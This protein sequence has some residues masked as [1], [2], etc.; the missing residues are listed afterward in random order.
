MK[1]YYIYMYLD[2]RKPTRMELDSISLLYEPFYVGKGSSGRS[3]HHLGAKGSRNPIFKAKIAKLRSLGLEPLIVEFLS[4][5]DEKEAYLKEEYYIAVIGSNY[6]RGIPDGPLTNFCHKAQPPNHKGKTYEDIYGDRAQEQREN[7]RRLQIEAGGYFSGHKHSLESREK[8]RESSN[9]RWETNS[10]PMLGKH[11]TESSRKQ[12]SNTALKN[13]KKRS[14]SVLLDP[15]GL[16]FVVLNYG[17][18]CK[19][20][21]LSRSTLDKAKSEGWAGIK[22]GKTKGWKKLESTPT[23]SDLYDTLQ[24]KLNEKPYITL[25]ELS[26]SSGEWV[27]RL[28]RLLSL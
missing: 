25:D 11:H 14:I 15:T 13:I 23:P 1:Q 10:G 3:R 9:R 26:S 2:P 8:I 16:C 28:K 22:S 6:I 19:Q 21:N 27:E 17:Q 5:E 4:F 12:M 18:F 7:R 20:F 24:L